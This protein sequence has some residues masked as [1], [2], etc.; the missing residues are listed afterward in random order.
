M[1]ASLRL[2]LCLAALLPVGCGALTSF[3]VDLPADG[4]IPGAINPPNNQFSAYHGVANTFSQSLSTNKVSSFKSAQ[5]FEGSLSVPDGAG[6]QM[7][8]ITSFKIEVSAPNLPTVQI[9]HQD[10]AEFAKK[11]IVVPLVVDDGVELKPYFQASEVTFTATP[12]FSGRAIGGDVPLH[13]DMKLQVQV[14]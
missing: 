10:A 11:N 14:L 8:L 6:N 12:T 4:V 1:R 7:A 2:G 5:I 3:V 9:V 13:V